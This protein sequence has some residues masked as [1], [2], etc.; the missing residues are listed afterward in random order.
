M[1]AGPAEIER[2]AYALREQGLE[3]IEAFYPLHDA[4]EAMQYARI[5]RGA[6]LVCTYGSDWHGLGV[7]GPAAGFDGFTIPR[8]TYDWLEHLVWKS[9]GA[10]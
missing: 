4:G 2:L 7:D 10:G 5:G 3:G 9:G 8:E 6:G 1:G